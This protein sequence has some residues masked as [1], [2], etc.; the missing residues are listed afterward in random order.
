MFSP[1]IL[2]LLILFCAFLWPLLHL[3]DKGVI[4]GKN[5]LPRLSLFWQ[6]LLHIWNG[7]F[8]TER[9]SLVLGWQAGI[10]FLSSQPFSQLETFCWNPFDVCF[11]MYEGGRMKTVSSPLKL[12]I[13]QGTTLNKQKV[14]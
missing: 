10:L 14:N 8:S 12:F 4:G 2:K 1:I 7:Y 5:L 13:G 11:H 3:F 6:T 9:M